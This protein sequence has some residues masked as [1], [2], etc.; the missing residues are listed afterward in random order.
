MRGDFPGAPYTLTRSMPQLGEPRLKTYPHSPPMSGVARRA[1]ASS[2]S[3]TS[4]EASATRTARG[5][6]GSPARRMG[7]RGT[8]SPASASGHQATYSK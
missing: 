7:G 1:A 2:A 3:V 8:P 6:P 4:T 5:A